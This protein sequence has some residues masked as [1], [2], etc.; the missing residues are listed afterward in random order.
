VRKLIAVSNE[1]GQP[2]RMIALGLALLLSLANARAELRSDGYHVFP[3]EE[4]QK[5]LDAASTNA[6]QK[7]VVVHAGTY[8]PRS[9]RQA[10][11]KRE[12]IHDFYVS[13]SLFDSFDSRDPTTQQAKNDWGPVL[14][15]GWTF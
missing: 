4:I 13:L 15:V 5:Y 2:L 11:A 1:N 12:I 9:K 3:G 10:L 8:A 14:S 7:H 6:L